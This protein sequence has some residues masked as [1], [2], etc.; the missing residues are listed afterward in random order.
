MSNTLSGE[1]VVIQDGIHFITVEGTVYAR[2]SKGEQYRIDL[3]GEERPA[4]CD[5]PDF[6]HRS[7]DEKG[8]PTGHQCKHLK[9]ARRL[10]EK[11][12]EIEQ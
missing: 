11:Q 9:A 4:S 2:G 8:N 6:K 5:C 12:T 1:Q 10:A 7:K 3:G